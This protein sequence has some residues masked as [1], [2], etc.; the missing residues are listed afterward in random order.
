MLAGFKD[1]NKNITRVLSKF[2][3]F[4]DERMVLQAHRREPGE[5]FS[6]FPETLPGVC[7]SWHRV[8]GDGET[9]VSA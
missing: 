2:P 1:S 8:L 4:Q 9:Q 5:Q 6:I 7:G 3:D